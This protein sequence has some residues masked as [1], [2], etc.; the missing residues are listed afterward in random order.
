MVSPH[1]LVVPGC[2]GHGA[3]SQRAQGQRKSIV[4]G[5]LKSGTAQ[6]CCS[7][8]FSARLEGPVGEG[9]GAG[10]LLT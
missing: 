1:E 7:C 3:I 4:E 9:G 8:G 2:V 10:D 5:R 6:V